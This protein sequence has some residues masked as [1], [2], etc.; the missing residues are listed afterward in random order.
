M[1]VSLAFVFC[2]NDE[3]V[4]YVEDDEGEDIDSFV[5]GFFFLTPVF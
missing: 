1:V 4:G 2:I 5:T 3:S